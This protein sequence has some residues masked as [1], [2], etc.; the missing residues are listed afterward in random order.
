MKEF[1]NVTIPVTSSAIHVNLLVP[2][3][4]S[5]QGAWFEASYNI[6]STQRE[7][8]KCWFL[9]RAWI[10]CGKKF[11][12]REYKLADCER[13]HKWKWSSQLWPRQCLSWGNIKSRRYLSLLLLLMDPW[14]ELIKLSSRREE[15]KFKGRETGYS[16]F[17]FHPK[18]IFF[19]LPMWP[20]DPKIGC[21]PLKK[22]KKDKNLEWRIRWLEW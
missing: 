12:P 20:I 11:Q 22:T 2:S 1:T 21:V 4:I 16:L 8:R 19:M 18:T 3:W 9:E 10:L 15:D 6:K 5:C 17:Q 7:K 14:T 13:G